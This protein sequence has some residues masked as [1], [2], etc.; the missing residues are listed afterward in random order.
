MC[1]STILSGKFGR[2]VKFGHFRMVRERRVSGK[3]GKDER[4]SFL[5]VRDVIVTHMLKRGW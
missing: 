5:K 1:K 3:G 4:G 2:L